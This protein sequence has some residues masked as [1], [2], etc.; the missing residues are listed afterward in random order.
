MHSYPVIIGLPIKIFSQPNHIHIFVVRKYIYE[1]DI[2]G[3]SRYILSF[4]RKVDLE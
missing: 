3:I 2:S 4:K 1:Q